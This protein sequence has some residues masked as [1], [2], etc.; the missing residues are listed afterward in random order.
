M[1]DTPARVGCRRR[2]FLL[3]EILT[4]RFTTGGPATNIAEF[5]VMME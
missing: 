4:S 5:L 1:I 2:Q 3:G